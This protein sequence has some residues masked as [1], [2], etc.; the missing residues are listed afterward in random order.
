MSQLEQRCWRKVLTVSETAGLA[1]GCMEFCLRTSVC[2]CCIL[3]GTVRISEW[4]YECTLDVLVF[5]HTVSKSGYV[6]L[7]ETL[8][9][10][11]RLWIIR[12]RCKVF[13]FRKRGYSCEGFRH[14]LS[15]AGRKKKVVDAVRYDPLIKKHVPIMR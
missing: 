5:G 4:L 3:L 2:G 14:E 8:C 7:V 10:A 12:C 15:V 1:Q 9:L 13:K 6:R 11:V